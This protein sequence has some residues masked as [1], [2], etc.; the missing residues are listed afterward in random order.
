[1]VTV[2]GQNMNLGHV[3]DE[4]VHEPSCMEY[5]AGDG[6]SRVILPIYESNASLE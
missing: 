5:V 2:V 3:I 1:M 4:M 6:D